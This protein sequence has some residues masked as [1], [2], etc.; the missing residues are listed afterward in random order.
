MSNVKTKKKESSKVAAVWD[1]CVWVG[2]G[3]ICWAGF[4]SD[5]TV[6]ID[7]LFMNEF[8]NPLSF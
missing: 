7:R 8:W 4:L 2:G 3:G 6:K 5:F 1:K